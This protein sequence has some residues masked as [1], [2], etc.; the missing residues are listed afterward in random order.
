[1]S[2][3]SQDYFAI[4]ICLLGKINYWVIESSVSPGG[5]VRFPNPK[6]TILELFTG[7]LFYT[8]V[9]LWACLCL[10]LCVVILYFML[11]LRHIFH[12]FHLHDVLKTKA[13]NTCSTLRLLGPIQTSMLFLILCTYVIGLIRKTIA[14]YIIVKCTVT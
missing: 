10:A 6:Q 4:G 13:L 1:M 8:L 14:Y 11:K 7:R 2:V 9:A 5:H 3:R 12:R